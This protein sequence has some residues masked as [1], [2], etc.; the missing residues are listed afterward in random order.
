MQP[1]AHIV[2]VSIPNYLVDLPIPSTLGGWFYLG[3]KD[4][5]KLIPFFA[6]VGGSSYA[7][8]K[9][10]K[11]NSTINPSIK[12]DSSK[13]VDCL[14]IEDLGEQTA[15]C[16]CWRSKKFPLC[17]GAHGPHNKETGDNVGPLVL[18]KKSK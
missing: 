5:G 14:N 6:F 17:D 16:R 11:P 18:S 4:W 13:V 9:L 7:A 3:I 12:K 1:V 15:F 2:K 8:Y 10:L